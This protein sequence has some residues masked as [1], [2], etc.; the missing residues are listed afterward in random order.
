VWL[1]RLLGEERDEA[2]SVSDADVHRVCCEWFQRP[3]GEQEVPGY[4]HAN[5]CDLIRAAKFRSQLNE[6]D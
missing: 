1:D 5:I 3:G 6:P 4:H 2:P